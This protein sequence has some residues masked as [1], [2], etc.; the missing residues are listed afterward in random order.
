[1]KVIDPKRINKLMAIQDVSARELAKVAGYSSHSYLQ[2]ILRG[3]ITTITPDRA[4]RIARHLQVGVDD[5]FMPRLSSDPSH[6]VKT[7]TAA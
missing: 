3:E 2:R 1:M 6:S 5:L 7:G 4:V